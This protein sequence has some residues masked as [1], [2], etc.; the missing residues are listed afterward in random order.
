MFK[1]LFF[2]GAIVAVYFLFFKKKNISHTSNE[3]D[4]MIACTKCGT[5]VDAKEA[6]I[7]QGKYYCCQECL[8]E[9]K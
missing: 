1:L 7:S 2:A 6:L 3:P 5:Y 8:K 4:P 9:A